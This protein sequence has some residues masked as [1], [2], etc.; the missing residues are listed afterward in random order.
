M[1]K[2]A[3]KKAPAPF[4]SAAEQELAEAL[5]H[6]ILVQ[7]WTEAKQTAQLAQA[8]ERRL[9]Q[10]LVTK[11]FG[12]RLAEGTTKAE[13]PSFQ[14]KAT[15]PIERKIDPG[16]LD[17]LRS[18][19]ALIKAGISIDSLVR[20]KTELDTRAYKSALAVGS[21]ARS[22]FDTCLLVTEGSVQLEVKPKKEPNGY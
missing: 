11:L 12:L 14:V 3:E 20:V 2:A 5:S 19:E 17:A 15:Q 16:V 7:Q 1:K 8:E 10:N 18:H 22:I 6:D 4:A 9:R 21:L 13:T